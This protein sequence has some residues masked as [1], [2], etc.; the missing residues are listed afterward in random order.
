VISFI[1]GTYHDTSGRNVVFLLDVGLV[2][3]KGQVVVC[4]IDLVIDSFNLFR[5]F[6][7][8]AVGRKLELE[9]L[10]RPDGLWNQRGVRHEFI[11]ALVKVFS[12][13]DIYIVF[14]Q[15]LVIINAALKT[16]KTLV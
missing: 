4:N 10:N 16:T 1:W 14:S 13:F 5:A 6:E 3:E 2:L 8:A 11:L 15:V 9:S 7:L 12:C